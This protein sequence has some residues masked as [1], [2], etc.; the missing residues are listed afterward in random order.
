MSFSTPVLFLTFNRIAT[1]K[2]VFQKIREQA[3]AKLYLAS[4][5]ARA[6]KFGE[7]ETVAEIRAHILANIDWP[8]E[9]HTLFREENLGCKDAVSKAITWFFEHEEMGI[10]LEDDCLPSASFF[11]FCEELLVKYKNDD[12]VWHIDGSTFQTPLSTNSYEFSKYCLIWG[13]ATWR[14]AWKN[15]DVEMKKFPNFE[16]MGFINSVWDK[17]EVKKYWLRNM[18]DVYNNRINTWDFQW[19]FALWINH[20]LTIRPAINM[21]KNIGFGADATHTHETRTLFESMFNNEINFPLQHPVFM[22]PNKILDDVC[23][24]IRFEIKSPLANFYRRIK[25]KIKYFS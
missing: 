10:I 16:S 23:S 25:R 11:T 12:R 24:V 18:S 1:T 6:N 2:I 20:G 22:L 15:Y 8:C 19:M 21:I 4:D 5:G 9:V 17:S 14:R 3:P 7:V 13:W